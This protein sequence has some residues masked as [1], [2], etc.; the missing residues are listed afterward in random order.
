MTKLRGVN[1]SSFPKK[2]LKSKLNYWSFQLNKLEFDDEVIEDR[3]LAFEVILR[4]MADH[5]QIVI[6]PSF[7]KF[8]EVPLSVN[9]FPTNFQI[10]SYHARR[11]TSIRPSKVVL[12][13]PLVD[14]SVSLPSFS[15]TTT[16]TS[17]NPT[18]VQQNG[19]EITIIQA[20]PQP[21]HHLSEIATRVDD[22]TRV[23]EDKSNDPPSG[24]ILTQLVGMSENKR[25]SWHYQIN[26]PLNAPAEVLTPYHEMKRNSDS[27]QVPEMTPEERVQ[28]ILRQIKGTQNTE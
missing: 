7:R 8:V 5:H 2:K 3:R 9:I 28:E 18:F 26:R 6:D 27:S 16:A 14:S 15:A 17:E 11:K 10:N 24:D 13:P 21:F 12:P 4:E 25:S 23:S 19:T 22:T 1:L 20:T